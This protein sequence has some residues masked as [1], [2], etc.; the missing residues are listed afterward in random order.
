MVAFTRVQNRE[1]THIWN[2]K[3]LLQVSGCGRGLCSH[4]PGN[5]LVAKAVLESSELPILHA[6]DSP[7]CLFTAGMWNCS[8]STWTWKAVNFRISFG[9]ESKRCL[10][11]TEQFM[12]QHRWGWKK[13]QDILVIC[14][15]WVPQNTYISFQHSVAFLAL[16]V[17]VGICYRT[18]SA[19]YWKD[20]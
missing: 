20:S 6:R 3:M 2:C 14:E 15:L 10:S 8:E 11:N 16:L 1:W 7:F 5:G 12:L 4:W 13:Q 17:A 19:K 18:A 9:T